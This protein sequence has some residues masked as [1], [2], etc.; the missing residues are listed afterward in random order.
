[1]MRKLAVVGTV[2]GVLLTASVAGAQST[3]QGFGQK[4][5]FIFSADRLV[6]VLS[7]TQNKV[8][9]DNQNP[10]VSISTK[11]S[12]LS[13][14]WGNNSVFGTA[15]ANGAVGFSGGGDS[16]FYTTPRVGFDYVLIPN[17]TIGGDVFVFFTLGTSETNTRGDVSTDVVVPSAN[18]FGLA[19]RVGYIFGISPLLSF[20]LRGGLSY[21][22]GGTS[23]Q[24]ANC[25]NQNDT[26]SLNLFG[27]D[28][29]SAARH[30]ARAALLVH[31]GS[32]GRHR[33]RGQCVGDEPGRRGRR[34]QLQLVD[35]GFR[36][37]LLVQHRPHGRP[38]RLVLISE[39]DS[40]RLGKPPGRHSVI[41]SE[42]GSATSAWRPARR[43]P[44]LWRGSASRSDPS[45][46][47]FRATRVPCR[48]RAARGSRR[49]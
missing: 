15:G 42:P 26:T 40:R 25:N 41:R 48:I 27:L 10:N 7:F 31:R 21:Y 34:R 16:T 14:L 22:H 35:H 49:R 37:V 30:L 4:G 44:R 19:P 28:I 13:L 43:R 3:G 17:L 45:Q 1:M 5:E 11:G 18:A 29:E 33:L 47:A 12:G 24:D 32:G 9:F 8:T 39:R 36:R 2:T 23:I 20:W 6:P 46:E 38:D